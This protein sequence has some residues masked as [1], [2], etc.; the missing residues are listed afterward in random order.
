LNDA[1]LYAND[2]AEF[3]WALHRALAAFLDDEIVT[4]EVGLS[5]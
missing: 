4:M 1:G 2:R 5:E 3:D